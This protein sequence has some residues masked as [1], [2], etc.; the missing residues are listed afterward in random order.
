LGDCDQEDYGFR[1]ACAKKFMRAHLDGKKLGVVACI[2]HPSYGWK[3]KIGELMR[4]RAGL[5]KKR[6]SICKITR[7]TMTG[8]MAQVVERQ[9]RKHEV[10]CSNP[11]SEIKIQSSQTLLMISPESLLSQQ[12]LSLLHSQSLHH[13][14]IINKVQPGV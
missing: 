3:D 6:D 2:C 8:D 7:A 10:L 13:T 12:L 1:P 14:R 11:S 4:S 5:H 9:L